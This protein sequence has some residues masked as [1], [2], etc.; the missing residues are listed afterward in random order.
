[1]NPKLE[2]GD[3]TRR[4]SP[5][6]ESLLMVER[7]FEDAEPGTIAAKTPSRPRMREIV[8]DGVYEVQLRPKWQAETKRRFFVLFTLTI[9]AWASCI[10]LF[11]LGRS[12][13]LIALFG[14][15]SMMCVNYDFYASSLRAFVVRIENR[16]VYL[17]GA[18]YSMGG[19]LS[20]EVE[21]IEC[22]EVVPLSLHEPIMRV[23]N[24]R[25]VDGRHRTLNLGT[26][27]QNELEDY[28]ARLNQALT[29]AKRH[30]GGY[31]D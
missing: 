31:R 26:S 27:N 29:D 6:N 14:A 12:E 16:R 25:F 13:A 4:E 17:S 23:V 28:T 20:F 2:A 11:I 3:R 9:A 21:A 8:K 10:I 30:S 7:S 5:E 24:A 18:A 22:F 19:S 15:L 1:V